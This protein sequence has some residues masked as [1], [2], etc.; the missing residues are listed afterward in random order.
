MQK[1]YYIDDDLSEHESLKKAFSNDFHVETE[2]CPVSSID[3]IQNESFDIIIIDI[4]MPVL[5]GIS[6]YFKLLEK[7]LIKS[8]IIIFKTSSQDEEVRLNALGLNKE[9]LTYSMS[10]K[11]KLLRVKNQFSHS[12]S[13]KVGSEFIIDKNLIEVR[14]N[15]VRQPFTLIEYKIFLAF[16]ERPNQMIS[17]VEL[18]N[19]VWGSKITVIEDNTINS[20]LSNLR[21]KLKEGNCKVSKVKDKGYLLSID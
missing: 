18:V 19:K 21:K 9:V 6:L 10:Y 17:K 16:A 20:H 13:I 3:R 14:R 4:K 5:D 1:V 11:E 2:S 7:A 8:S 15:G 12:P